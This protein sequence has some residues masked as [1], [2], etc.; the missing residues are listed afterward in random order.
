MA[1]FLTGFFLVLLLVTSNMGERIQRG[2]GLPGTC[3]APC[4]SDGNQCINSGVCRDNICDCTGLPS[5]NGVQCF[6]EGNKCAFFIGGTCTAC[7]EGLR[8]H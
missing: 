8:C 3:G 7:Q 2:I 6:N 1:L 4:L 5:C